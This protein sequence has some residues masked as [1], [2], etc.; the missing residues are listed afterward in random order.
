[1]KR[2]KW[3]LKIIWSYFFEIDLE[4]VDSDYSDFLSVSLH[5]GQHLLATSRAI[6]SYGKLYHN[7][8]RIFQEL[9]FPIFHIKKV[10]ILG[11][12]LGS[13]SQLLERYYSSLHISGVE[14]DP[15]VLYLNNKYGYQN[16]NYQ[17]EYYTVD[18][19]TFMEQCTEK[20][21]LIAIDLFIEDFIPEEFEQIAFLENIKNALNENGLTI[22]NRLQ[23]TPSLKHTS[24]KFFENQFLKVFPEGKAYPVK[25]NLMLINEKP[26]L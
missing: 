26:S 2:L 16:E 14:I 6:Y 3:Q 4:E 17:F 7:Y 25:G 12:G 24:K 22:Y 18:A 21:D 8:S 5:K 1:M 13:I 11:Y 23:F 9:N 10:L 20:Y 19:Y 15:K